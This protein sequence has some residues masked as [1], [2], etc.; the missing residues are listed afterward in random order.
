MIDTHLLD[1]RFAGPP[2]FLGDARQM[3]LRIGSRSASLGNPPP[4]HLLPRPVTYPTLIAGLL[5]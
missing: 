2:D 4:K 3:R 1:L 5:G